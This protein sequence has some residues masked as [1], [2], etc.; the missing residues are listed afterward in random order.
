M[1]RFLLYLD[2]LDDWFFSCALISERLRQVAGRL[3]IVTSVLLLQASLVA[4]AL[5]EPAV[6]AAVAA[7]L[8]VAALYRSATAPIQA[9]VPAGA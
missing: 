8:T 5:R 2:E 3:F 4:V 6:G 9:R 1:E 7:L